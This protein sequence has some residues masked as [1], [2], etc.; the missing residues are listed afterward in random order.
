MNFVYVDKVLEMEPGKTICAV[1][2][3]RED[4]EIFQVHYPGYPVIPG[5]FLI[6]MM[7]Q[8]AGRCLDAERKDRGLAMLARIKAASFRS[9]VGP[10]QEA[11]I[12]AEINV[13]RENF[14][15]AICNIEVNKDRV[16]NGELF[17]TFI[18]Y[19]KLAPGFRDKV[20]ESYFLEMNN[21]QS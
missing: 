16:C 12:R 8:T 21:L 1:K 13:N 9:Y 11:F 20:L 14:A 10:G 3:V 19:D 15:T 2:R 17:F 7:A 6:E 5:S 4:E 18:S